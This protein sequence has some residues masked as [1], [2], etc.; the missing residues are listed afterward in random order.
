MGS[1][2]NVWIHFKYERLPQF[3]YCYG[4]LGH[5]DRDCLLWNSNKEKFEL[6]GF[7]YG[8]WLRV[9]GPLVRSKFKGEV[10][11]NM[12]DGSLLGEA[13]L[14]GHDGSPSPVRSLVGLN[15]TTP[16]S[17]VIS[18]ANQPQLGETSALLRDSVE[19]GLRPSVGLSGPHMEPG[20]A[21]SF[22][23]LPDSAL[24]DVSNL[25][26]GKGKVQKR[27]ARVRC[28]ASQRGTAIP[29]KRNHCHA[30]DEVGGSVSFGIVSVSDLV[31]SCTWRLSA[32]YGQPITHLRHQTWDLLHHLKSKSDESWL[33]FGDF[34]EIISQSEKLGGRVRPYRQMHDF[35]STLDYC[36]LKSL[37]T[38]GSNFT[39][40]N[41]KEG[42]D[43]I[44]ERLDQFTSTIDWLE[45]YP[46]CKI[47]N[48]PLSISDHSCLL[49]NTMDM[50]CSGSSPVCIFKFEA[51]WVGTRECETTIEKIW[52]MYKTAPLVETLKHCGSGLRDW[53]HSH[54]GN[55]RRD[56]DAKRRKLALLQASPIPSHQVMCKST[57]PID[58][59]V[60]LS[61]VQQ[62]VLDSM[63]DDLTRHF[64]DIE[65]RSAVFQMQAQ[66]APGLNGMLPL[67]FQKYW[68]VVGGKVLGTVL[69]VL[70]TGIMSTDLNLTHIVLILKKRQLVFFK[71]YR[72]IS[73]C[74]VVYKIIAK[75][76][77][78]RLKLVLPSVISPS[79]C[80]FI[81]G[82]LI[83]DNV[84]VAYE[85][86]D[87]I[88]RRKR[89]KT[90]CMSIKLD[91]SKAYD[92]VEWVF[93]EKILSK[94]QFAPNF[95]RLLMMCISTAS[96]KVLING[97]PSYLII[98]TRG[99]R[100]G[101]PL[102]PYLFVLCAE[103]LS[104]MLQ[105]AESSHLLRGVRVCNRAPWINHLFFADDSIVF[106]LSSVAL[107]VHLQNILNLYGAASGQLLN[108]EKTELLFSR[109]VDGGVRTAIQELW[110]VNSIHSHD[111]YLG[112]PSFVG[113]SKLSTFRDV[114]EK[115]LEAFNLALSAK[116]GWRLQT[117]TNSL[118]YRV[119]KAKYFPHC[120]FLSSS[121]GSNPSYVWRSIFESQPIIQAGHLWRIAND[122]QVKIWRDNW[123]PNSSSRRIIII[124]NGF[125]ADACV[126]DLIDSSLPG[127]WKTDLLHQVFLP[128]EALE[129]L[130]I[131][132]F[133]HWPVD[134]MVWGCTRN[135][136]FSVRSAYHLV[137]QLR[138]SAAAKSS[139]LVGLN[140]VFWKNIWH[141]NLPNKV[142]NF[143][144]KPC[145]NGLSTK[146]Q[147]HYRRIVDSAMCEL[148]Y[149][150]S[151]DVFHTLCNCPSSSSVWGKYFGKYLHLLNSYSQ[152]DSLVEAIL[153]L[154]D[155]S[156]IS[157]FAIVSWEIWKFRNLKIFQK[158]LDTVSDVVN[159]YFSYVDCFLLAR[160]CM[161]VVQPQTLL[162]WQPP[163]SGQLKLNFDGAIFYQEL[164]S[165]VGA[166]LRDDKE[167]MIMAMSRLEEGIL[168]VEDVEAIAALRALQ[169]ISHLILEGDSLF[170]VEAIQS[171]SIVEFSYSLIIREIKLLLS[172]FQSYDVLHVG[173]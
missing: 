109:N 11:Q 160:Q 96:Y 123:L 36:Q 29:S 136:Q 137:L 170:I 38:M 117:Y 62:H 51:M 32:I 113:K 81:P 6:D 33:A 97:I 47:R 156:T 100:Q 86:V 7:P 19:V 44:Q 119:F 75:V 8:P 124:C 127:R 144:L 22:V 172:Q 42:G 13:S 50:G 120:D 16:L 128:F 112:L 130:N 79:Q 145:T 151:E 67:F 107:N 168:L 35:R 31:N 163:P 77:A 111:R 53:S 24:Y 66:K 71:D 74:N 143:L 92:R 153:D 76:L 147:L 45:Q 167:S 23:A 150:A 20:P 25:Q 129:I 110:G 69:Q 139:S 43:L 133:P 108:M 141:L 12:M 171:T 2:D 106:C 104:S 101:C 90:C 59:D 118:F 65:I 169:F 64:T 70:N 93:L 82:R 40:S 52:D 21:L 94:M 27:G 134:K 26:R 55:I 173:R 88:R 116:Q 165:E 14:G 125:N 5:G 166:V 159:G 63:D 91:M 58:V 146:N 56:L 138:S 28:G 140:T 34:N 158:S 85:I 49:L 162:C 132:L 155:P 41:L 122:E 84:L 54:F 18:G 60:V 126:S 95:I 102:S 17:P 157:Y 99:L 161:Q 142:K 4:L 83:T 121:I 164:K 37:D 3:C 148:C 48:I 39:W 61:S 105:Q 10:K 15:S 149:V 68:H 115:D 73:L 46:R 78:N 1:H 89:D 152:F 114:K 103:A 72:P 154:H 9:G 98:P 131:P 135:G 87:A 57:N 30:M 80:A